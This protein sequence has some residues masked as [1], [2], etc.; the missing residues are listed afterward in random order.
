M[1]AYKSQM[2][3]ALFRAHEHTYDLN[4]VNYESHN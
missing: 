2:S 3:V 4:I 1:K